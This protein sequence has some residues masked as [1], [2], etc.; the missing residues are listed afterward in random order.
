[1][2]IPVKLNPYLFSVNADS[3]RLCSYTD[4]SL[5]SKTVVESLS[6]R[7]PLR[8]NLPALNLLIDV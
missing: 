1:M 2:M 6:P 5:Y 3:T 8:K 4:I 7:T